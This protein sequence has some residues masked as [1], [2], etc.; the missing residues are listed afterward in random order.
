[1]RFMMFIYPELPDQKGKTDQEVWTPSVEAVAAMATY[2]DQ[3][4]KAGVLISLDGLHAPAEAARVEFP[5]G[6][7]PVVKDGPFTEAKEMIGGYWLIDVKSRDEAIE[8]AKRCPAGH[9]GGMIEVRQVM[10]VS[11][12]PP[13]LQAAAGHSKA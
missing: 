3:L 11:E 5:S 13:E 1:M 9:P 4:S 7:V 12:F 10:E 6:K 2:N 8:W